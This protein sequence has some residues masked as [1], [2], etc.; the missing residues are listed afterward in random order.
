[1]SSATLDDREAI[2]GISI[3]VLPQN[4]QRLHQSLTET[5]YWLKLLVQLINCL[6]KYK[7]WNIIVIVDSGMLFPWS[8]THNI[9]TSTV[10]L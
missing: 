2:L 6:I 4:Q 8:V 7:D 1:M 9:H 3:I 10:A 5:H